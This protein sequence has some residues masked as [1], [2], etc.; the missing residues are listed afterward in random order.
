MTMLRSA[1]FI[2]RKDVANMLKQKETLLWTFLMPILF[3]FFIGQVTGGFGPSTDPD[4]PDPIAL[5]APDDGGFLVE[6]IVRRLEDENYRVDRPET[7]EEF[8]SYARRLTIPEGFTDAVLAGTQSTITF[9]RSGEGTRVSLD[10]VRVNRAVYT[11]LADLAVASSTGSRPTPEDFAR[12]AAMPRALTLEIE[13][14]GE[15]KVIPTGYEQTIPGT[16]V[17]F[18]MLVLL[19]SG[20]ILLVIE[21]QQGL[22]RRL[23]STPISRG[24]VTLGKWG[25]RM[26]LGLIQIGFA[27]LV[28]TLLFGMDWGSALP[29]VLLLLFSWAAFN[30]SLGIVLGNL[31]RSE[32]QMAGIGVITSM[33]LAALGGCWWPIEIT[34]AWMQQLQLALPTGWIMDGLH[35]LVSF[36]RGSSA[37]LPHLLATSLGAVVLG[38]IGARTFRYQ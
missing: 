16:M 17:M 3:F 12:L 33:V 5:R 28:G 1:L 22:L 2:A 38:W 34:P 11:V 35:T 31:A 4:R 9:A 23:A 29:M 10:R 32:A 24:A 21:R 26:A 7:D 18:T 37:A 8:G 27:M 6:E 15:R 20:S 19:T 36:G 14:A 25:A 30:A 13:P